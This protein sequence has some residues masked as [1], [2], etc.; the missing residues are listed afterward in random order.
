MIETP[1]NRD[2]RGQNAR[3]TALALLRAVLDDG[4]PLDEALAGNP[5]LARLEARDRAFARL[6]LVTVLRRLGQVDAAIDRC[7]DR[8]IRAKDIMLRHILRLGTAQLLF[9][10]TPPHAAVST[11]LDLARG[12]RLAGQRGLLNAVLRRLSREGAAL[13]EGQDAARLNTPDWLWDSWCAAYGETTARAIAEAQLGEPPLDLSCKGDAE[14]LAKKLGAEVLPGGSLR[15]P[16]GQGDVTRLP[17]YG[18]GAWWV[19]DAAAAL[20][21]RLLGDVSGKQVIDLCAAPGGKTAQLA[22]AGAEVIAV[23][24]SVERLQRLQENLDR[25]QLGAALVEADAAEWSPPVPADAVLLDAPCSATGTL[26]RHPDIAWLKDSAQIASLTAAQDRLLAHAVAMVKPGGLLVY[27]VCSLQPE[28]GPQRIHALLSADDR[29]ERLPLAASELPGF[30]DCLTPEGDLRSLP[31]HLP[32]Q[33]GLDGFY[34]CRL[35]R[36]EV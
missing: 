4:R 7:L 17:G 26:R 15:L 5:H 33:G 2:V 32:A 23:E 36:R 34:A 9:L 11:S 28:E 29:V 1:K 14:D 13:V 8:P 10:E 30:E 27:A 31:C 3:K 12:P 16:A 25:L 19:Q 24:R 21:A 6:L 35:R 20:P 18:E 22:A